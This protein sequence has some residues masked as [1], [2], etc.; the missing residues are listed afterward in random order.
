MTDKTS[1]PEDELA[2]PDFLNRASPEVIAIVEAGKKLTLL[3]RRQ[4][5]AKA[6]ASGVK[7]VA[8]APKPNSATAMAAK[9]KQTVTKPAKVIDVPKPK[10]SA[11][12][13]PDAEMVALIKE[14]REAAGGTA[15]KTLKHLRDMG[16]SC[17]QERFKKLY[18]V[19]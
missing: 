12:K 7:P 16:I 6:T 2:I 5:L 11:G 4:E 14:H 18:A 19:S 10:V 1:T 15:G 13:K 9:P 17:S 3:A 8:V